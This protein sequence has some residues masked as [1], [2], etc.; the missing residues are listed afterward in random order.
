MKK[1]IWKVAPW[2]EFAFRGGMRDQMVMMGLAQPDFS[3]L[4][5]TLRE[6]YG[7]KGWVSVADVL[8]FV[9]GRDSVPQWTGEEAC[10]ELKPMEEAGL[11]VVEESKG[12]RRVTFRDECR[13]RF[14]AE[15]SGGKDDGQLDLLADG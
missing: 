8:D 9:S 7:G 13:I 3:P 5:H 6:R 11:L 15:E 10:I 4:R 1:A 14:R 12:R 2:G